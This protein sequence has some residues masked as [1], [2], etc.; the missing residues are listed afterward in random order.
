V[1]C[2]VCPV[3][4]FVTLGLAINPSLLWR[5]SYKIATLIKLYVP[6]QRGHCSWF[7]KLHREDWLT[8]VLAGGDCWDVVMLL[9]WLAWNSSSALHLA[10]RKS[11]T[12][13]I[14]GCPAVLQFEVPIPCEFQNP[15]LFWWSSA[16]VWAMTWQLHVVLLT[17]YD[18]P[19]P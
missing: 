18:E 4:L 6:L 14:V 2:G 15:V 16:A 10:S 19:N 8:L 1:G 12:V 11:F 3:V 9:N 5:H 17:S 13:A 7:A